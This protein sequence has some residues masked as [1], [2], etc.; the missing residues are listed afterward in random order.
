VA[1]LAKDGYDPAYGARPVKRAIQR[2]LENPI[3]KRIVA[4]KYPPGAT[5]K[6]TAR[7]GALVL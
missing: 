3:A 7:N 1:V 6:V 4:G 5:V 2:E